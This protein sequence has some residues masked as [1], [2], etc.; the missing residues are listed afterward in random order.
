MSNTTANKDVALIDQGKDLRHLN[1]LVTEIENLKVSY[2]DLKIEGVED[3]DGYE[4]VRAAIGV[5]RPKRTGLEAE[6]KSVVKP[7][8]DFVK[9]I[10]S[11]YDVITTLIQ[12]GPGGELE[13]K[14]KK[15]AI[16]DIIKKQKEEEERLAEQKVNNRINELI[17]AGMVFDGSWYVIGDTEMGIQFTTVGIAD[18]RTM[19]DLQHQNTLEMV[20]DKSKKITAE[21]ERV[22]AALA[23]EKAEKE[24]A[25]KAEREEFQKQKENME[26]LQKEMK[27]KEDAIKSQQE[28][29]DKQKR[30]AE[31]Q[32]QQAEQ[33]RINDLIKHRS[34]VLVGL[35][36][37]YN[38]S[39]DTYTFEEV[40]VST[41]WIT[42]ATEGA[43]VESVQDTTGKIQSKKDFAAKELEAEQAR[44]KKKK[45]EEAALAE[46]ERLA[47]LSDK[48]KMQEYIKALLAVPVPP[49]T[50]K[51]WKPKLGMVRDFIND[52][53]P[54]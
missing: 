32:Q 19:S 21:K 8:N 18:I 41:H 42:T 1:E 26:R 24:A 48:Q 11:Q 3:K 35:G 52:N 54:V 7:Y 31:Q 4:K 20:A 34:A 30:E 12:E 29:L 43:W 44:E 40:E 22:A 17:A 5:L 33:N 6:R 23:K 45:E 53:L 50:T 2:Q 47:G 49:I 38:Q 46:K 39:G 9:H 14:A 16:D 13:L 15:E 28:E 25:E 51:T 10:N 27:E 37:K 36:M